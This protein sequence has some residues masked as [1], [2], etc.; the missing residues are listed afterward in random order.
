MKNVVKMLGIIALVAIIGLAV[1]CSVDP[2]EQTLITITDLPDGYDGSYAYLGVYENDP[3]TNGDAAKL[4]ATGRPKIIQAGV[5]D[6][7]PLID[8]K[9]EMAKVKQGYILLV[10]NKLIDMS[11]DDIYSGVTDKAWPLGEGEVSFKANQ[12]TPPMPPRK[13]PV[14]N[15]F[16]TYTVKL[17][18]ADD[19]NIETVV[20]SEGELYIKDDTNGAGKTPDDLKFK[21][22]TW[23]EVTPPSAVVGTFPKGYKFS[24][25]II[26]AYDD[27]S[28]YIPS[29]YTAPGTTMA[30]VKADESGPTFYMYIYFS[31]ETGSITFVRTAFTKKADE[32]PNIVIIHGSSPAKNRVYTKS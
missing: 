2:D 7:I 14:S 21:I 9:G 26:S 20:L 28:D 23:E 10:V 19:A 4:L 27:G 30:D 17:S 29:T 22:I 13:V 24:G 5:V 12:F 31:G 18:D 1:G 8:D 11:G 6:K 3:Q 25:K 15:N 16:G 32:T